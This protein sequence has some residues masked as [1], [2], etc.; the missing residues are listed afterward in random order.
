PGPDRGRRCAGTTRRRPGA[1]GR[2]TPGPRGGRWRRRAHRGR[3]RGARRRPRR[4]RLRPRF[5]PARGARSGPRPGGRGSGPRP[6]T[7]TRRRAAGLDLEPP[8]GLVDLERQVED[9]AL[10]V[11]GQRAHRVVQPV[12]QDRGADETFVAPERGLDLAPGPGPVAP[13]VAGADVRVLG[14]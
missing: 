11:A 4:R 5:G 3:R 7:R 9:V 12:A 6:G 10:V 1:P 8:G 2:G 14:G 13:V